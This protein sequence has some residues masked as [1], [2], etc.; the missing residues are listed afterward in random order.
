MADIHFAQ[1]PKQHTTETYGQVTQKQTLHAFGSIRNS[2]R[3]PKHWRRVPK[4]TKP[5]S[6]D[7]FCTPRKNGGKESKQEERTVIV[8][9]I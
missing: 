4:K 5:W 8:A 1:N 7:S 2:S 6:A 3:F 9:G